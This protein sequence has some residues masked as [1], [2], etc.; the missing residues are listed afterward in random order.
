[1]SP[2][3]VGWR[4]TDQALVAPQNHLQRISFLQHFQHCLGAQDVTS[5]PWNMSKTGVFMGKSRKLRNTWWFPKM[6]VP[7]VII[8]FNRIFPYITHLFWGTPNFR[9][10]PNESEGSSVAVDVRLRDFTRVGFSVVVPGYL[11]PSCWV[12]KQS[13]LSGVWSNK[14]CIYIYIHM[15]SNIVICI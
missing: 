3:G 10:A 6:G 15:Q 13:L 5:C 7:L 11:L 4:T 8:H 9:K 12:L 14:L 2:A 1:M